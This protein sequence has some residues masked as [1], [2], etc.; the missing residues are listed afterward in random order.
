MN[1]DEDYSEQQLSL[2]IQPLNEKGFQQL[3]G[4]LFVKNNIVYDLSAAD[5]TQIDRIEKEGLFVVDTLDNIF[6]DVV[7]GFLLSDE[8]VNDEEFFGL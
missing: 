6:H 8:V 7:L 3:K 5:L 1:F 2:S 4:W